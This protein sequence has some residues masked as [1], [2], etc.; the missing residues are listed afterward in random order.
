MNILQQLGRW[1]VMLMCAAC[2]C[3][4]KGYHSKLIEIDG[5][6]SEYTVL[7][8]FD[9]RVIRNDNDSLFTQLIFLEM[10]IKWKWKYQLKKF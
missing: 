7:V 3:A 5:I 8:G 10:R 2:L 4:C 1:L 9:T 6:I